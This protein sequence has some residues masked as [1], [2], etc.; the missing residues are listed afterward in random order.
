[1]TEL[2]E[3]IHPNVPM[4]EYVADP[5]PEPSISASAIESRLLS[6]RPTMAEY[7]SDSSISSGFLRDAAQEGLSVALT[8]RGNGYELSTDRRMGRGTLLHKWFTSDESARILIAPADVR[9][10]RGKRWD[11]A[12]EEAAA[13]S[14]DAVVTVEDAEVCARS[15]LSL[16]AVPPYR[17][18]PAKSQIRAVLRNWSPRFCEVSHRWEPEEVPGCVCRIRQDWVGRA[19][20]GCWGDVQLKT[21]EK[22]LA[23]WWRYWRRYVQRASAFYQRGM[24]DLVGAPIRQFVVV[25]RLPKDAQAEGWPYPWAIFDLLPHADSLDA[26][27]NLEIVPGL[28]DI[29]NAL[30][31]GEAFGPEERGI[32][33]V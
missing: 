21:T 7:H 11:A 8:A 2:L 31:R 29:A 1:M 22:S 30:A 3:G 20:S 18:T 16:L 28:R 33:N 14:A 5:C 32:T 9:V 13:A 25:A 27:W 4:P 24:R 19:P 6:W 12:R 17:D 15:W 26:L 23:T 10:R